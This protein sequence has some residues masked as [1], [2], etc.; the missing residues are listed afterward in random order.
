MKT[1]ILCGGFG[2]RLDYEGKLKAKPMIEIGNKPILIYIIENFVLQGFDEFVFCLGHKSE[3][4]INYFLKDKKKYVKVLYKKKNNLKFE[5]KDNKIK[6]T[7]NL[8][9]TG[10]NSGTGG[11]IKIAYKRL[12]LNEDFIMTYGDGLSDV[13]IKKLIKFHYNNKSDVSL[14]AVKPKH[15]Y[16]IIKL[17]NNKITKF[18]NNNKSIDVFINGGFFVINKSAINKIKNKNT[19]WEK[20]PLNYFIKKKKLFAFTHKG[21]WKSLDTMKDKNDFN[22]MIKKGK[23]PWIVKK[24]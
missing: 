14:T 10:S 16:G 23:K 24:I 5:F 17:K 12:G 1:F 18:D 6:F 2:T 7:G 22:E 8:V 21:F 4:I 9:Y 13:N 11:R 20:E 3:T 15:R 19:Y